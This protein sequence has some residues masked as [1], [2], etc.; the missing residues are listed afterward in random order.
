MYLDVPDLPLLEDFLNSESEIMIIARFENSKYVSMKPAKLQPNSH[1]TLWHLPSGNIPQNCLDA[2]GNI[3]NDPWTKR[4][5]GA[6]YLRLEICPGKYQ[7]FVPRSSG[8]GLEFATSDNSS[9]IGRS[10]FEWVGNRFSVI[11]KKA[12]PSTNRWW[13]YLRRWVSRNAQKIASYGVL[14]NRESGLE[15]WTFPAAYSAI[16]AG[17]PRNVNPLLLAEGPGNSLIFPYRVCT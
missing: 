6:I 12:H 8:N 15:V 10:S 5:L 16:S 4:H 11:G 9:A 7:T 3:V 13:K 17:R 2:Q 14:H 1:Y